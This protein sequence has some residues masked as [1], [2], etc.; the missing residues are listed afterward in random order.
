MEINS[1]IN[2]KWQNIVTIRLRRNNYFKLSHDSLSCV[3]EKNSCI[4]EITNRSND[5]LIKKTSTYG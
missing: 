4:H 2:I 1:A 5:V 3:H